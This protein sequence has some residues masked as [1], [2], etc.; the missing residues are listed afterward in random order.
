MSKIKSLS[1]KQI[2]SVLKEEFEGFKFE[3]IPLGE[4]YHTYK[5]SKGKQTFFVKEV[6]IHEAQME[7]FLSKLKY[8]HLPYSI[9]PKFLEKGILVR[10]YIKGNML[11]SKNIDLGLVR[12]FACMR[13]EM[14][15]KRFFNKHNIFKLDNFSRKDGGFYA[16]SLSQ[17]FDFAPKRLKE[18]DKYKLR[19][20]EDYWE[21]Y[22]HLKKNKKEII[23][24]FVSMPFAKQHQDF[25]EDNIIV[26]KL[27]KQN[28][29]DWG[30]SYGYH[31]FMFDP[32]PFLVYNKKALKTYMDNLN[33]CK[34][35]SD[36]QI[37]RWLYVGLAAK[38]FDNVK[39]RLD[40]SEY[41]A[42][43]KVKCKKYLAYEYETFKYLLE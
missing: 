31:P 10:Q 19:E 30:S 24:G 32:A 42:D 39:W 35:A 34:R 33:F 1:L 37:S 16:K 20:V 21:I 28:L 29:I 43:T 3:H 17:S 36:A 23:K 2:K 11:R 27:G 26:D 9:F 14:N 40:P 15:D 13:S 38:F 5:I 22:K 12:D 4:M 6:K 8:G 41:R 7:Y 18:L 25:R